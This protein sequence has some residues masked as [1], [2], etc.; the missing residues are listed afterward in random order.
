MPAI[1]NNFPAADL[2]CPCCGELKIDARLMKGLERLLELAGTAVIVREAYRCATRQQE[3]GAVSDSAH[4]QGLAADVRIVGRTLQQ[5][6]ELAVQ[7]P[8]FN[9]GGIGVYDGGF[10]HVDVR[11]YSARWARVRGQYVWASS[12]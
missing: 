9:Q 7:V 2:A 12:T 10:I 3:V 8:E 11:S 4:T 1:H 6:Y 5:M